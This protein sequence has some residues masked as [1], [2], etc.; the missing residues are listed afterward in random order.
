MVATYTV[1]AQLKMSHW[2]E[3]TMVLRSKNGSRLL[4]LTLE[5]VR[6]I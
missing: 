4:S 3:K 2:L 5:A 1:Y 6:W